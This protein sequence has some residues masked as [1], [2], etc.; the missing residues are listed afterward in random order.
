MILVN[1]FKEQKLNNYGPEKKIELL[2]K[3]SFTES[4][5]N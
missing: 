5:D 1:I 3:Y 2:G 4:E